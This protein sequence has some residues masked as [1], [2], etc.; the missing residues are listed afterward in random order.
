MLC[1]G[2]E[3]RRWNGGKLLHTRVLWIRAA[4]NVLVSH[5]IDF[6][7]VFFSEQASSA[8]ERRLLGTQNIR[9]VLNVNDLFDST[10]TM[11]FHIRSLVKAR[12]ERCCTQT[13]SVSA[14][15]SAI[16]I[17]VDEIT[18]IKDQKL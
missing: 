1:D 3:M 5:V 16:R 12:M 13:G 14:K 17:L 11:N 10:Q 2:I 4:K 8:S 6:A 7:K 9:R 15:A 18:T